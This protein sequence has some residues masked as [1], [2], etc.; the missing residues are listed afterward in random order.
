[1]IEDPSSYAYYDST[2]NRISISNTV[3]FMD[4][5][6]VSS[7]LAHEM[8]HYYEQV[9]LWN[10]EQTLARIALRNS[11]AKER[12][13]GY[14]NFLRI[15]EFETHILDLRSF[16]NTKR[17]QG[18]W[19]KLSAQLDEEKLANIKKYYSL[20]R[21]YDFKEVPMISKSLSEAVNYVLDPKNDINVNVNIVNGEV[22]ATFEDLHGNYNEM[23]VNLYGLVDMEDIKNQELLYTKLNDVLSWTKVRAAK[24]DKEFEYL[25]KKLIESAKQ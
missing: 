4:M 13:D 20:K 22:I 1:M 11:P 16:V 12:D 18:R 17:V 19:E 25:F 2:N 23:S 3:L 15:D 6:G 24:L 21:Q 8:H 5:S 9:K 7:T 14:T 10:G